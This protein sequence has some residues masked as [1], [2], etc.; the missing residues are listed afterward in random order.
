VKFLESPKNPFLKLVRRL[1]RGG[2][3]EPRF[4]LEGRKLVRAALESGVEIDC[5]LVS[6]SRAEEEVR[7]LEARGVEVVE[8]TESLFRSV[9][10]LESP[11]GILAVG[12]RPSRSVTELEAEGV[13]LVSAGIQD[14][15][16]LGAIAR[17]GEAAG[18]RAIV[19]LK[20]SAD[21]FAPKALRGSMGS[22]LRVP[23]FEIDDIAALRARGFRLA[24]LV[25]R[26]G[27]DFRAADWTPPVAL[28]LGREASGLDDTTV[29]SAD[30]QVSIPMRGAVESLNV[31]TAAALVLYEATRPVP[32]LPKSTD[33]A[34]TQH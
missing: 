19:L 16:N 10:S 34:S 1:A 31:A 18:A 17:I 28:L 23:V 27:V 32:T 5:A 2:R 13:V 33:V 11:E 22:L 29:A 8:V 12:L 9:S 26:G 15:G 4:L 3:R 6:G 30:L 24:A 25:P 14:P 21:P 20:G 7:E